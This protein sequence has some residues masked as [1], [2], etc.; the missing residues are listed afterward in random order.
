M[1][2]FLYSLVGFFV[3]LG[4]LVTVH[5]Y[6]HFWVA[7]KLGVKVL[8]F[9]IGFG[10]PLWTRRGKVDGTEYVIGALPLGGYVKMLDE[11][12]GEVPKEDLHRAFNRQSLVKR[13]LVVLAGPMANFLFA[14]LAYWV[15]FMLGIDGVKPVVGQVTE[16]SI[17]YRGGFQVGDELITVA[18]RKVRSWSEHR[19]YL[20]NQAISQSRVSIEVRDRDGRVTERVLDFGKLEA[21]KLDGAFLERGVGLYGYRPVIEPIVGSIQAGSPADQAGLEVNDRMVELDGKAVEQWKD[22]VKYIQERPEKLLSLEL[23]RGGQRISVELRPAAVEVGG[24]RIGRIGVGVM[25]P[26]LPDDLRVRVRYGPLEAL[27]RGT[28]NTWLMGVLTLRMLAKMVTLE[29]SPKNISGPLTIAQYAGHSV[30]VGIDQFLLFL[31]L[32]SISLGV[33]NLLPIP[34]LDG[35]HLFYYLLEAIRRGPLPEGVMLWGQQIG[36]LLL[37]GLMGLAFYNDLARLLQ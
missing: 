29:V 37:V 24:K 9:S 28:G 18:G 31:A 20:F 4:I 35:G 22:V 17:A 14:I 8:R 27:W 1:I 23:D 10:K 33:L 21:A 5:E 11:N 2:E 36:I 13:S 7:R 19:M 26:P 34:V 16:G 12:E 15:V 6:G 25:S 30:R 32:V 3:A